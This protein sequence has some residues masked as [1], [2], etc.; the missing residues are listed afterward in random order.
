MMQENI[1]NSTIEITEEDVLRYMVEFENTQIQESS[2]LKQIQKLDDDPDILYS[3]KERDVLR[4]KLNNIRDKYRL[5]PFVVEKNGE[6]ILKYEI[7][8]EGNIIRNSKLEKQVVPKKV[9]KVAIKRDKETEVKPLD[10]EEESVK[11]EQV[12]FKKIKIS[13]PNPRRQFKNPDYNDGKL[14]LIKGIM[15][16]AITS[17]SYKNYKD[18]KNRWISTY[19]AEKIIEYRKKRYE[20]S[21]IT[22]HE[23]LRI[24]Y[25]KKV[26]KTQ[27]RMFKAVEEFKNILPMN[28]NNSSSTTLMRLI[29][30]E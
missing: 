9:P 19:E 27:Q 20:K 11:E 30:N 3:E 12:E 8:S 25:K 14:P 7:D 10:F 4:R 13:P 24:Y 26:D 5:N 16:K 28:T 22:P 23:K 21:D 17:I 15:F 18:K 1:N 6:F 29:K 2:V